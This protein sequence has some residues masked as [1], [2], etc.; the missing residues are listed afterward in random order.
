[1][2]AIDVNLE[3]IDDN[4]FNPRKHYPQTKVREMA[5]SLREIG[6]RQV[7]EGRH[8]DGRV[9]LAYGHMRKRGFLANQ[10]KDAE[11]WKTM[12]INVKEISDQDMFHYAMEENLTRTDIT[13][14]EVARCIEAF[15]LMF[16]DVLDEDIAQKHHMTA[17]HV[18]NMKRVLRLPEKILEK[19]DHG[20]L[21]FTQGRELLT[22]EKLP[23][24]ESFMSRALSNLKTGSKVYGEPNTV[25][26]LQRS[27]Y[28][29]A[30]WDFKPL[31]KEWAGHQDL[32]FDTRA[33]GC[34]QCEKMF[35]THP[36]KSQAA[37]YCFD[38]ECWDRHQD[39]AREVAAAAA[40]A[41]MEAEVINRAAQVV[42][43]EAPAP[44][45]L[46]TLEK[47]G[48]GWIALD[49]TGQVIA[50]DHDKQ[51][52]NTK[53]QAYYEPVATVINPGAEDYRLNHT[54][55][56]SLKPGSEPKDFIFDYT[57]QDLA[58]AIVASGVS[59]GDIE[60]VK[61]YKSSGKL[62][63]AGDVS[64]GWSKCTE[65]MVADISQEKSAEVMTPEMKAALVT[66]SPT[67]DLPEEVLEKAREAAGTRAEVLDVHP[68][69]DNNMAYQL[70]GEYVLLNRVVDQMDNPQECLD[71]CTRGFH[72]AFDSANS[73]RDQ[74]AV[75]TD[76]KCVS[77]KKSG[78]TRKRNA[79][80]Q[81]RKKAEMKAVKE[82][83]ART[84]SIGK[85]E[86]KVI[87]FAQIKGTHMANYFY[88][89][90]IKKPEKWLW[91]KVSAGVADD[92]RT[93]DKLFKELDKLTEE[94]LASLVV[95]F[96]LYYLVDHSDVASYEIKAELPLRWLGIEIEA[97]EP[98]K[99]LVGAAADG[100]DE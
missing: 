72:Y 40:K 10:K 18:S 57:A 15:S 54:Y 73:Q 34:L 56:I 36:T 81:A 44:A 68:L 69:W 43:Q 78:L 75:C 96:M 39:K 62:G 12:P 87:L 11:H 8:V 30:R 38:S 24:A 5:Q 27:I 51:K 99:E 41:K 82:A 89:Q 46:Y 85:Q 14:I 29:T 65:P 13:P 1:M 100:S 16:P 32:I 31:D 2:S 63:T 94:N 60:A 98:E 70:K 6:L 74:L 59:P 61:V 93:V 33:A 22:V 83:I 21:T 45:L 84:F 71:E 97:P 3:V 55:R 47:R 64:A 23:N 50:M 76:P 77:K 48:T 49:D 86:L 9:Q 25:E 35:R 66:E 67:P 53:A 42:A 28:S 19:I 52:T 80:G 17:A 37:H 26:G 4:P 95:E 90:D 91:D 92:K 79:A 88:G 20:L 58:T 7:P